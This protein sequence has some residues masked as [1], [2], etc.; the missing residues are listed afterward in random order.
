MVQSLFLTAFKSDL[1]LPWS[2]VSYNQIRCLL[3]LWFRQLSAKLKEGFSRI[4]YFF[5]CDSNRTGTPTWLR[6][7]LLPFLFQPQNPLQIYHF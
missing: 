6:S 7:P 1:R 3:L 5:P 2:F 4:T